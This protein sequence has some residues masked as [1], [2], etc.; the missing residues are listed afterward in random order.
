MKNIL[1]FIIW[2]IVV[3][4]AIRFLLPVFAILVVVIAILGFGFW[5]YIRHKMKKMINQYEEQNIEF[6]DVKNNKNNHENKKEEKDNTT[7]N[8]TVIDVDYEDINKD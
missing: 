5:L 8:G 6:T 4:F 1:S 7:F 2:A 3:I